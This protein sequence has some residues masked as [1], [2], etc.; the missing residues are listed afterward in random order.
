[1]KIL[2]IGN[3]FSVDAQHYLYELGRANGVKIK[4]A[5]LYI[6]GCTLRLHYLNM[7]DDKEAYQLFINGHPTG[8]FVSIRELLA[9]D[10]W[11]IIT[12]QQA[13][14]Q[15]FNFD[16][17][18]PYIDELADYV[19]TYCPKS[20]IYIHET[21]SYE[22]ESERLLSRG[23]ATSSDM[24]KAMKEAYATA[25]ERISADGIIPSGTAMQ[26]AQDMG[27]KVHRDTFHA[28]YGFGRY[29]LSSVWLTTLGVNVT[30]RI[31]PDA[32]ITEQEY[33]IIDEIV[34]KIKE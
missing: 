4:A 5:N 15:S 20:K 13:S 17:Y 27:I 1:M 6:G 7:L 2:S 31:T 19:R 8:V 18:I 21:W 33:Q 12:I 9:S 23:F 22:N 25:K 28:S 10:D 26:M 34:A 3:S 24:F 14:H 30:E 11:D 29:L 32:P 16:N